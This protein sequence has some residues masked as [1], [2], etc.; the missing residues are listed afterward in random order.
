[1]SEHKKLDHKAPFI[2]PNDD[3]LGIRKVSLPGSPPSL[4]VEAKI[5]VKQWV[6]QNGASSCGRS[7]VRSQTKK[8]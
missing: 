1:M 6:S 8:S 3:P 5:V 7:D 2:L 4:Q